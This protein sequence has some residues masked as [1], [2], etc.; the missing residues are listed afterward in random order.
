MRALTAEQF[1]LRTLLVL[2]M[3]VA[4]VLGGILHLARNANRTRLLDIENQVRTWARQRDLDRRRA[5]Q[6]RSSGDLEAAA[7]WERRA[8]YSESARLMV[9]SHR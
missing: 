2:V 9:E 3:T 6:A 4:I 7:E 8:A 5:E 1:R